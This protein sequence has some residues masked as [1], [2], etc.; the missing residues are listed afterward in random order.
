MV[1]NLESMLQHL[2]A[3]GPYNWWSWAQENAF[4]EPI[5]YVIIVVKMEA[6]KPKVDA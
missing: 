3:H 2:P 1:A 4:L 5:Q 6:L